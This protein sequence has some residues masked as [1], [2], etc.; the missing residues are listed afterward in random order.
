[1]LLRG[2][3]NPEHLFV[4]CMRG[5][6]A[7]SAFILLFYCLCQETIASFQKINKK[8]L[9][10]TTIRIKFFEF[11]SSVCASLERVGYLVEKTR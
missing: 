7:A 11:Y 6:L 2:R 3:A 4:F 9:Q 8:E 1:M 5:R 10:E